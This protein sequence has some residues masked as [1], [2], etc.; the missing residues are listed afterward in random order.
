MTHTSDS[1]LLESLLLDILA[2]AALDRR[3]GN[4]N[5]NWNRPR[6]LMYV[7]REGKS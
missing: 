1:R 2:M 3:F 5:W 4:W 7:G 6:R